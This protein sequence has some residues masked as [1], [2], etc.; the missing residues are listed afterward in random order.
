MKKIIILFCI[1]V[2]IISSSSSCKKLIA[3]VFGGT[4]V[5]VPAF[6]LTIP[7]IPVVLSNEISIGSY[8]FYFN[9]DSTVRANTAGAFGANSVNSIKLKKVIFSL[10]NTD[11]LNNLANFVSA[12]VTLQSNINSTPVQL[13]KIDFP[14]S[15]ASTYTYNPTTSPELVSYLKGTTITYNTYGQMRRITTKPLNLVVTVTVMAD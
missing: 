12:R 14:D 9:L 2:L 4:N 13:F 3:A 8:S 1:S 5:D 15:T 6:Q 7:A 10:T 11:S